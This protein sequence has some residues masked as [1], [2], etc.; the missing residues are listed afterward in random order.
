[1]ACLRHI[2]SCRHPELFLGPRSKFSLLMCQKLIPHTCRARGSP[3]ANRVRQWQEGVSVPYSTSLH[4]TN[5]S[6][7]P[8]QPRYEACSS[9]CSITTSPRFTCQQTIE[10][11]GTSVCQ[12]VGVCVC[13]RVCVSEY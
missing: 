6:N 9:C 11:R 8:I 10:R 2:S 3:R 12:Y 5:Y 1:M 13:G 7:E 4:F